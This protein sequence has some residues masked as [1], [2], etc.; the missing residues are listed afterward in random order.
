MGHLTNPISE[1]VDR[2]TRA[3]LRTYHIGDYVDIRIN[4]EDTLSEMLGSI[5]SQSS[6]L[7]TEHKGISVV[8]S[9]A[10]DDI[11]SNGSSPI[12][13]LFSAAISSLF[14][15]LAIINLK[16]KERKK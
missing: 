1:H 10:K 16:D 15:L 5:T 8:P 3:Y 9:G 14:G 2:R 7:F 13:E 12:Q 11:V 6:D 4:D